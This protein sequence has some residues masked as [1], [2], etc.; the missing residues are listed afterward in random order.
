MHE[1]NDYFLKLSLLKM[2]S[3]ISDAEVLMP[4]LGRYFQLGTLY[5]A[6]EDEMRSGNII[7][8]LCRISIKCK[9]KIDI[10]ELH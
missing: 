9:K 1:C 5:N 8:V 10:T 3:E 2:A 6:R 7:R 4:A